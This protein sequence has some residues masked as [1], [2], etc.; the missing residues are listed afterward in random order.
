MLYEL[1]ICYGLGINIKI[2]TFSYFY[3]HQ[4]LV[5]P[6]APPPHHHHQYDCEQDYRHHLHCQ[7]HQIQ[8]DHHL[9]HLLLTDKV[10][11]HSILFP[12]SWCP[13]CVAYLKSINMIIVTICNVLIV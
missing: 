4:H 2:C 10:I 5:H 3:Q 6:P 11:S 7:D 8:H 1:P 13:R 12:L 9:F